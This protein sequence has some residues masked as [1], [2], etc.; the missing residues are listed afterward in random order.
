MTTPHQYSDAT[1]PN[2]GTADQQRYATPE[3]SS[4]PVDPGADRSVDPATQRQ[5]DQTG[6]HRTDPRQVDPSAQQ[7]MAAPT[8]TSAPTATHSS[9]PADAPVGDSLFGERDLSELRSRWNDVQAAFV[10]DPRACVQKADSLVSSAVEQLTASFG[11][12]RSRLEDQW[13]RGEE[14]STE[15][16][17]IALKHYR[18]FFDRI[19][20]V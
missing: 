20:A 3:F 9:G 10:D 2:I 15:D 5:V 7:G 11:Q 18:D 13:S 12:T 17:R 1:D 6:D 8:A 19:L 4:G 16:L 14:A